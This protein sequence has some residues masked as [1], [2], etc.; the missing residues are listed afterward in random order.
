MG[1]DSGPY[2]AD[3]ALTTGIRPGG[4]LGL[5]KGIIWK[6]GLGSNDKVGLSADLVFWA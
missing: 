4:W 3:L 2:E 5:A 1:G 6:L